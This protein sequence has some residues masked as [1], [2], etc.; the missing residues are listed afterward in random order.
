MC[1]NLRVFLKNYFIVKCKCLRWIW[2]LFLNIYVY[3]AM[4]INLKYNLLHECDYLKCN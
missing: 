2:L 1:S 3:T 4:K